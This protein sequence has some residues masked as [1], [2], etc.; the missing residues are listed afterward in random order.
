VQPPAQPVLVQPTSAKIVVVG[1]APEPVPA[2][3]PATMPQ[4]QLAAPTVTQ[5]VVAVAPVEP[6]SVTAPASLGAPTGSHIRRP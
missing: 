1:P 6:V 3:M 5:P 2:V 4:T